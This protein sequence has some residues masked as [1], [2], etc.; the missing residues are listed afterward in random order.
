MAEPFLAILASWVDDLGL[1]VLLSSL[2][3]AAITWALKAALIK[4]RYRDALDLARYHLRIRLTSLAA[5]AVT[6]AVLRLAHAAGADGALLVIYELG[7]GVIGGLAGGFLSTIVVWV[8]KSGAKA[9]VGRM[10]GDARGSVEETLTPD[11]T[12]PVS[13]DDLDAMRQA[14]RSSGPDD[15]GT[16]GDL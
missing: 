2:S 13:R 4:P 9:L 7:L 5:G 10:R 3:A 16:T 14:G 15:P 11:L 6:G 1:L 12:S 8:V